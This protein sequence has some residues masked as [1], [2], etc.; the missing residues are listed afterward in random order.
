MSAESAPTPAAHELLEALQGQTITTAS[1]RP[2]TIL[3]LNDDHV[4]VGTQ[5]SPNGTSIPIEWV[6]DALDRLSTEGEVE[7]SVA[8]IGHRSAFVGAVLLSLPG[9]SIAATSP[10]RIRLAFG[11]AG[12]QVAEIEGLNHWWRDVPD[13][14]YWL[15][16]TDRLDIGVD[17]HAPQR[18]AS[19]NK[20]PG[21][22]LIWLVRPGDTVF[23]YDRN[24]RAIH[25]WSRAVGEVTEDPV[26]WLSH[27]TATRR[28]LR[29]ARAQ[30]GW[31]LDLEGPFPL[32]GALSLSDLRAH[33]AL[34]RSVLDDL[35]AEHQGALYFPFSFYGGSVLRPMQPYLNKLP[36][37]LVHQLPGSRLLQQQPQQRGRSLATARRRQPLHRGL[38]MFT[39][40]PP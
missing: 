12:Q 38:A 15:E 19:G 16:I 33:S 9:A 39:G 26:I 3:A 27:R 40:Q 20:T 22:S 10:P 24:A 6:Q 28:R 37:A 21:Y 35:R 34:V 32:P 14:Q 36:A 2:N 29:D 11:R 23:H 31:W 25:S 5:R 13:E 1:G 30:P 8:S 7:I 17:L 4:L 18:D